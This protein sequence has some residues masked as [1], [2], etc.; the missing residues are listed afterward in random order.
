[1]PGRFDP[2]S[3]KLYLVTDR[4]LA[5][6]RDVSWVVEE[7]VKGGVTMVQLREKD[8]DTK[9][10]IKLGLELKSLLKPLG[11]PLII[12]DR[13]DVAL[14]VDADGVHIGQSDMP[15][16]IAR[17]L[18]GP[19]KIIGLSVEN[20]E[21]IAKANEL[22]VD[23]VGISPVYLTSTKTDT[24]AAFGLDGLREAVSLSKHPTVGIGG[25]NLQTVADVIR[26]G[27]DGVA[28]VSA[29]MSADSPC[30][31]SA[32]LNTEIDR[33][34]RER[35][36]SWSAQVWERSS[37]IYESILGLPFIKELAAVT[38]PASKFS[39]YLAQDEVYIGNYGRQMY[40]LADIMSTKEDHDLFVAYADSGIESEKIMHAML[41][42]RFNVDTAVEASPVTREYN[43]HTR[44]AIETASREIGL[45]AMLPCMWIYNRVGLYILGIAEL[46]GNPYREWIEEYGNEEFTRS[47][48]EVV[49]MLDKWALSVDEQTRSRMTEAY[50]K[51][52][53]YEYAF[54]DY[55]YRGDEADYSYMNCLSQWI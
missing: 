43:A 19:D 51:G 11:I 44:K 38:L 5:L 37:K 48:E 33:G 55:G 9:D 1:M 52:A 40:E 23:Y 6:G 28:V 3:L 7:A 4:P 24:A 12:N 36:M 54:W 10:F 45:A 29:I 26:I 22:D 21:D 16:P 42:E 50:L 47:T 30:E 46:E 20:L 53:L 34:I 17:K 25:M 14:A 27:A 8:I 15:Y 32:K 2:A 18:L 49:A 39:R 35:S 41:I 31:V 13:V